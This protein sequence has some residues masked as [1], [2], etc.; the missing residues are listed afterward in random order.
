MSALGI[1]HKLMRTATRTH[2][3]AILGA[4]GVERPAERTTYERTCLCGQVFVAST[5]LQ[6]IGQYLAHLP[7]PT[8]TTKG[9]ND[10]QAAAR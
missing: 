2:T 7:K 6:S 9:A 4:G 1:T 5:E 8:V 3:Y 10:E